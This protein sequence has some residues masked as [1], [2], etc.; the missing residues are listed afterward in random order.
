MQPIPRTLFDDE[1]D[2][3]RSALTRL[4]L[5]PDGAQRRARLLVFA[6]LIVLLAAIAVAKIDIA[7]ERDRIIGLRERI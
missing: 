6:I 5:V 7:L 2:Q 3:F 4:G 1:H